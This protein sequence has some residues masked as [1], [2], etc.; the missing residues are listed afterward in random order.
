MSDAK[1]VTI[2]ILKYSESVVKG[3]KFEIV[4]ES[5]LIKLKPGIVGSAIP[6]FMMKKPAI[7]INDR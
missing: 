1:I 4:I 7:C 3:R 5:E 6:L 2:M